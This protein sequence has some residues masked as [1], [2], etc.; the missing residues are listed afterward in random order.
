MTNYRGHHLAVVYT[1]IF[2]TLVAAISYWHLYQ[3]DK[4]VEQPNTVPLN[5]IRL[6]LSSPF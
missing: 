5:N 6:D 2:F 4:V 3:L 1:L